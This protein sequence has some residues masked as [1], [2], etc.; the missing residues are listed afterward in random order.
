MLLEQLAAREEERQ[1][2]AETLA[3]ERAAMAVQVPAAA[4]I[5]LC[6]GWGRS[7]LFWA[8]RSWV[9]GMSSSGMMASTWSTPRNAS[10]PRDSKSC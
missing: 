8:G 2:A 9:P 4:V 6:H 1:L 5:A 3:R 7:H 10:V